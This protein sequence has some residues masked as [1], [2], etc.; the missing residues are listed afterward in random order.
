[1]NDLSVLSVKSPSELNY[2]IQFANSE[3][4]LSA[5]MSEKFSIKSQVVQN[6][7]SAQPDCQP[8]Y[9]NDDITHVIGGFEIS[10]SFYEEFNQ[11][12]QYFLDSLSNYVKRIQ[13]LKEIG[14]DDGISLNPDSISACLKFFFANPFLKLAG[15]IV[16]E[17]GN[18][19]AIWEGENEVHV[20]LQFLG[21]Q[22][23]QYVIF[24]QRTPEAPVSRVSG[25]DTM[26]GIMHQIEAFDLKEDLYFYEG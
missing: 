20:G 10:N 3:F 24:K 15:L 6:Q 1:M 21:D 26:D 14:L 2:S 18:L 5:K 8:E 16:K 13:D 19:R 23:L 11:R 4:L 7:S 12:A 17:N 22:S 25:R 9:E